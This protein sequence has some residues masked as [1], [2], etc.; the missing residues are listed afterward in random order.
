MAITGVRARELPAEEWGRL[1]GLPF[2]THGLP[3]PALAAICVLETDAGEI[4]GVWAAQTAVHLEG[5]WI[6]PDYRTHPV[7]GSKL[8]NGM[9]ALLR[10]HQIPVSFTLTSE[11]AVLVLALR[12]GFTRWHGDLLMLELPAEEKET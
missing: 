4:V 11:E 2:A 6:H 5:L 1:E 8:L 7:A 3:D 10:Q 12:A 9:K